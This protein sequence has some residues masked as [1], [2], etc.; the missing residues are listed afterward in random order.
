MAVDFSDPCARYAALRD[1]YYNLISG[2]AETLIRYKGPEGEREVRFQAANIN[3]LRSEMQSAQ[4][5]CLALTSG[6]NPNRRFAIRGGSRRSAVTQSD[7]WTVWG[8]FQP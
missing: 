5:E 2:G 6:V 7:W 8:Q 4:A 1:A 3:F